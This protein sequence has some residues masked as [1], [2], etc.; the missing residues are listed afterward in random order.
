MLVPGQADIPETEVTTAIGVAELMF[1]KGL[2][3]VGLPRH[4]RAWIE[5]QLY[6]P[7]Y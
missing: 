6:K 5:G 1:D 2:A 3:R 4:M 7:Q